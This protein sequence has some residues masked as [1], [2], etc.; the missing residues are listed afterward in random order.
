MGD[1][2][3]SKALLYRLV[4]ELI[5]VLVLCLFTYCSYT[6]YNINERIKA[7]EIIIVKIGSRI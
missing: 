6:F 3:W 4:F 1:A 2:P 5:A 7:A